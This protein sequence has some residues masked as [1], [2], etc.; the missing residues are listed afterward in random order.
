VREREGDKFSCGIGFGGGAHLINWRTGRIYL[1]RN[2]ALVEFYLCIHLLLPRGVDL[3]PS[4]NGKSHKCRLSS[5]AAPE[6][7]GN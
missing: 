6:T 4:F 3:S 5:S 2:T 7:S 1:L